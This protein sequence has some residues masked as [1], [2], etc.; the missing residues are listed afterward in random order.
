MGIDYTASLGY[1]IRVNEGDP[2]GDALGDLEDMANAMQLEVMV[3]GS[4]YYEMD[5]FVVVSQ[6]EMCSRGGGATR[7]ELDASIDDGLLLDAFCATYPDR[8]VKDW[9]RGWILGLLVH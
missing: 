9:K 2:D 5:F 1:G 3:T 7:I 4:Y 6:H 8:V